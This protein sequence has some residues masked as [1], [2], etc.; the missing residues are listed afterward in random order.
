MKM[1]STSIITIIYLSYSLERVKN[2]IE[3]L[4][5]PCIAT[6]ARWRRCFDSWIKTTQDKFRC[7]SLSM[8]F[9]CLESTQNGLCH[10]ITWL[11]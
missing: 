8:L 2:R 10:K 9:R 7:R 5:N 1:E 11:K 6:K 3:T 4:S